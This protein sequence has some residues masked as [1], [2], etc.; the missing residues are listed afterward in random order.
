MTRRAFVRAAAGGAAAG[1]SEPPLTLPVRRML[2]GR[3]RHTRRAL[4]RFLSGV[5]P[6]AVR[7]F[8]R[9]GIHLS[10]ILRNGEIKLSPGGRPLFPGIEREA[11]NV[12][13]TDRIPLGWD[14]GRGLAG[15]TTRYEGCDLCVIALDHAHGHQFPF[16]SVNTCVHELL[17]VLFGD[18]GEERPAGVKG[19]VR[20]LRIDA[21]A[22]RMWL[23]REGA[24]V[25]RAARDYV[26]RRR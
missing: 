5:W 20:E 1:R 23:F 14:Q 7:D 8:E 25:R 18:V 2:D 21:Y 24:A 12:V 6:E 22:T 11:I 4:G 13:L 19:E 9:C 16:L 15:V 26:N 17:H 10:G 3:A